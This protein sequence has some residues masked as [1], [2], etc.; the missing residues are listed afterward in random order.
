VPECAP[1]CRLVRYAKYDKPQNVF[2]F[3]G[4]HR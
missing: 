4:G 3:G 1:G 2:Y